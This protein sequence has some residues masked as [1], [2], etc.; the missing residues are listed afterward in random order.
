METISVHNDYVLCK[1]IQPN[2]CKIE[3]NGIMFEADSLPLYEVIRCN[4]FKDGLELH[5]GDIVVANSTG[6]RAMF[7]NEDVFMFKHENIVCKVEDK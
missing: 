6:T 2:K 7:N 5:P 1:C 4:N 3:R